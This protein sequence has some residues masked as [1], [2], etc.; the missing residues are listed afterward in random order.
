[1]LFSRRTFLAGAGAGA[2]V[3]AITGCGSGGGS[4]GEVTFLVDNDPNNVVA[5]ELLIEAFNDSQA[6]YVFTM[7]TRPG[8]TEGD[9]LIKTRL[10]T[11][12]MPDVFSYNSGSLFQAIRPAQNL[13]D[14]SDQPWVSRVAEV[15]PPSV[16]VEGAIYGAPH[17]GSNSG[18]I[19]Y[20]KPT[21]EELG[22]EV[23]L[24]WDDFIANAEAAKSAG[25]HGIIQ[26]YGDTYTS[27]FLV[28]ADFH[29]VAAVNPDFAEQYTANE[30]GFADDPTAFKA[31]EHVE[32]VTQGG[33]VNEDYVSTTLEQ[34][35][36][37]LAGGEGAHYPFF[38]SGMAEI[39]ATHADKV[40]DVGFFALPGD[41]PETNG[42]TVWLPNGIY[43]PSTAENQDAATAF[44]EFA[45][46][47]EGL[48]AMAEGAQPTGPYMLT[49]VELPED[50]PTAIADLQ[51]YFDTDGAT[52]P[53]LEFSS[54]VKGPNLE[55]ILIELG[56]GSIDARTAAE[57]Y[58]QDVEKQAQQLGLEGW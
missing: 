41:D 55:N 56:T 22:L 53:A 19:W 14:L 27:Q 10:S 31:F 52:T 51:T 35:L 48:A 49:D 37:Y 11:Q 50:V 58:D 29:N 1:M 45:V 30:V 38:S 47:A 26:S 40:E 21:Y 12:D 8:G 18:G 34:A 3:V 43:I 39:K 15:Y 36:A 2:S 6:D 24:T 57:R 46:S 42:L 5:T 17:G 25:K 44:I 54:P 13:L 23:P 16:S 9:N 28:L 33:L 20:H 4:G 7:E 32:Q